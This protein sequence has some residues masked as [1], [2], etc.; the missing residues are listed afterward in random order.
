MPQP[1]A[2][3]ILI[4]NGPYRV[5][6]HPMYTAVLLYGLAAVVFYA[7]GVK[8][9]LLALLAITLWQKWAYEESLLINTYSGYQQYKERTHAILPG[10]L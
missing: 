8:L 1:V 5:I 6:R 3:G 9:L 2:D 7:S 10:I 4:E